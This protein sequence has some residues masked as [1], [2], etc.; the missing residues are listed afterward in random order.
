MLVP[1]AAVVRHGV[2]RLAER[3]PDDEVQSERAFCPACGT[4]LWHR[5]PGTGVTSLKPGT[6][7]DTSW[8]RPVGHMWASSAQAWSRPP[9]GPLTYDRQPA[10]YD[11]LIAAWTAATA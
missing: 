8:L 4:R 9:P 11:D 5:R 7:D 6:L 2:V 1:S 10:V 3:A